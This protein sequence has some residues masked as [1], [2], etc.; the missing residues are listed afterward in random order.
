M[1]GDY[2][3]LNGTI[4]DSIHY[5]TGGAAVTGKTDGD[6]TREL[7]KN[8][9]GNQSTAGI[10]ISETDASN[11]PG[12]YDVEINGS[13]GFPSAVGTYTLIIYDT[14]DPDERWE[15]TYIVTADGLGSDSAGV[16]YFASS[17]GDGRV[18]DSGGSAIEGATVYAR[19]SSNNLLTETTTDASGDWAIN[20]GT[21]ATVYVV[22]SGYQQNTDTVTVSGSTAT[23]P[24]SN[25]EL[26]AVTAGSGLT[27][28]S[29]WAYAR[30]QSRNQSGSLVD[31]IIKE[32]VNEA[33]S[34]LAKRIRWPWLER[35]GGLTLNG[36]YTTGTI[37][38]TEDSKTVTLSGGTWPS[39][40]ASGELFIG[41]QWHPVD[42]R[43]SDTQITLKTAYSGATESGK[44]YQ[45]Y[46]DRYD[47]EDDMLMFGDVYYGQEWLWSQDP[48]PFSELI[49]NK[50][51]SRYTNNYPYGWALNQDDLL[52]WP[53]PSDDR[54]I[55]YL[56][57]AKPA[58]L[59]SSGDSAD[60]DPAH[61]DILHRAI[62]WL[63]A[64]RFGETAGG[65]GPNQAREILDTEVNACI[66]TNRKP[67]FYKSPLRRNW[68]ARVHREGLPSA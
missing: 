48:I 20:I 12:T 27:A 14:S 31:Q 10:T 32:I 49:R 25:I 13:T 30:R 15:M 33:L 55:Q 36:S 41:P 24:G 42:T 56:Y 35:V 34:H 43:D 1:S 65:M 60:W 46:Q 51:E 37:A 62:D 2:F 47:L 11:N 39:W 29:L 40:A 59:S 21:T 9:T 28:S 52:I 19:D 44:D 26:T 16:A 58:D 53:P 5:Y 8:G 7:I 23:G 57:Y 61:V 54:T 38:V 4:Y 6:F 68:G 67:M 50:N 22:A 17:A 63:V 66:D 64:V 18:V 3:R 45:L